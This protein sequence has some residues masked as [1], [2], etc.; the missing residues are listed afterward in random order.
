MLTIEVAFKTVEKNATI[1]WVRHGESAPRG[2]DAISFP[3]TG[4]GEMRLIRV[5][6]ADSKN[7]AG[8]M[9]QLRFDPVSKGG[10][11]DWVKVRSIR[12]A[13]DK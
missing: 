10:E 4:D 11:G 5:R 3:I 8:P 1:Y 9:A 7:Y 2:E 13:K 6:L 12:L